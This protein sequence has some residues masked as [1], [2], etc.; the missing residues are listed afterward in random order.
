MKCRVNQVKVT[1]IGRRGESYS[2]VGMQL[3]Y[4]TAA[5]N[6]AEHLTVS[7]KKSERLLYYCTLNHKHKLLYTLMHQLVN[8]AC[9]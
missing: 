8:V 7:K 5:A 6:S 2:S 4:S 1:C 3:M 9:F